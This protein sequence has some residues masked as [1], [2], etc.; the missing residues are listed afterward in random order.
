MSAEPNFVTVAPTELS[1]KFELRKN[2][3]VTMQ[4]TNTTGDRVA[5]K[6]KT[7]SPKK[8]CVRPSSG[9]IEGNSTKEVQ[10]IL[11]SQ[12]EPPVSYADCRDKFLVQCIKVDGSVKEASSELFEASRAREIRQTKLRV[13]LVPPAK[14]PSPVPEGNESEPTSPPFK[15]AM[16][17]A[18]DLTGVSEDK[19]AIQEQLDNR[20]RSLTAQQAAPQAVAR[21]ESGRTASRAS[22]G[23]ISILLVG[24]IAFIIGQLSQSAMPELIQST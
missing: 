24:L 21:K 9:I 2:I 23:L 12:R 19:A 15:G 1:F 4:L 7:T 13:V 22:Y 3:P 18:S 10:V 6:V 20:L 16:P 5:F 14:P 17:I 11:Q 8:Y